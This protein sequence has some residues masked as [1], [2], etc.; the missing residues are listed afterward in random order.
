MNFFK[1]SKKVIVLAVVVALAVSLAACGGASSEKEQ[2]SDAK[3]IQPAID[4]LVGDQ[5]LA[6][7]NVWGDR[8]LHSAANDEFLKDQGIRSG[9][10]PRNVSE[11]A[12]RLENEPGMREGLKRRAGTEARVS[13]L[14]RDFMGK[15]ARAKGF[16]HRELMVGWAV[17]SHNLWVLARLERKNPAE[18]IE[19]QVPEAA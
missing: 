6:V 2:T 8:A 1:I 14:I 15:P 17:L 18:E 13:I 3:Q 9:L 10:C 16:E 4:R 11:L 7:G 19:S 5:N 12:D